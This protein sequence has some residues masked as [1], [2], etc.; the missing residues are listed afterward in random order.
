MRTCPHCKKNYPDDYGFCLDDGA[1]L[2]KPIE[3]EKTE[4]IK[5]PYLHGGTTEHIRANPVSDETVALSAQRHEPAAT[6]ASPPQTLKAYAPHAASKADDRPQRRTPTA[7]WVAIA[8]LSTIVVAGVIYIFGLRPQNGNGDKP[9]AN[10]EP[11]ATPLVVASATPSPDAPQIAFP[12]DKTPQPITA[13]GKTEAETLEFPIDSRH[14]NSYISSWLVK[15]GDLYDPCNS[16]VLA[17]EI[18]HTMEIK[19]DL[20]EEN[21]EYN[22][23]IKVNYPAKVLKIYVT[24]G[25]I[26][27]PGR[28]LVM[29]GK[30]MHMHV[31]VRLDD[32]GDARHISVGT[33]AFFTET[34]STQQLTGSVE[35]VNKT[36]GAVRVKIDDNEV[37]GE[38]GC[39]KLKP[40]RIGT[41][42]FA[43][44]AADH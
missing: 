33:D 2:S 1:T 7:L 11:S 22:E 32:P 18:H 27:Q 12:Q 14:N 39:L 29:L 34:G 23:D 38:G 30:I 9:I 44:P 43:A 31:N 19:A 40:G 42:R 5:G 8:V 3:G 6:V 10:A 28:T 16:T 17:N 15:E 37:F 4:L 25:Q 20:T 13:T 21:R 24:E 26:Y 35:A 36:S 41:V